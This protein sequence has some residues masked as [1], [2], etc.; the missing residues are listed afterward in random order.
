MP[1]GGGK[2]LCY[3]MP[4]AIET[5]LTTLVVSPLVSLIKDQIMNLKSIKMLNVFCLDASTKQSESNMILKRM[6]SSNPDERIHMLYVTPEKIFKSQKFRDVLNSVYCEGLLS[7]VVID[8]AHC[9]SQWGHDFRSDYLNLR[10]L[11]SMFPGKLFH[12]I[13]FYSFNFYFYFIHLIYIFLFYYF[14]LFI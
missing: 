14:S 7:R 4:A 3:S 6:V 5:D 1:T 13:F 8:E 9:C 12:Y 11:K 2:S 10:Q